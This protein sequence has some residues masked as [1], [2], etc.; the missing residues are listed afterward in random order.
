MD[1][2]VQRTQRNII[3]AF[4]ELRTNKPIEKI[5]IKELSE[6][7]FINK[8]TFYTHYKDI[9]DL[10]EQLENEAIETI[11]NDLPHPE[12]L[13]NN[14]KKWVAELITALLNPGKIFDILFSGT[15]RAV[16][17]ERLESNIKTHIY[18]A[19]PEY[20][21]NLEKEL[22]LTFLI[23]GGFHAFLT[24]RREDSNKVISILGDFSECLMQEYY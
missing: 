19:F 9:Y 7:A 21:D 1:L 6:R 3:N 18:R 4:I 14:P 12:D 23:Q 24:H 22:L 20:Q 10:S 15:R 16:L 5:T 17:L 8:A 2:R 11:L 13:V